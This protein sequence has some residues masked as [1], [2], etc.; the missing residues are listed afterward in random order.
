[1]EP[2]TAIAGRVSITT[3]AALDTYARKRGI[4]RS[5]AV[6]RLIEA[7]LKQGP[8]DLVGHGDEASALDQFSRKS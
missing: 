7:A 1:M 2:G 8:G 4:T 5:Q 6:R 3:V